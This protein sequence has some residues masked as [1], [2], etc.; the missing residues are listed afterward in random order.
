MDEFCYNKLEPHK[1]HSYLLDK[2][3]TNV[4]DNHETMK[5]LGL[6]FA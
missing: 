5:K 6:L 3:H 4:K 1:F 2:E